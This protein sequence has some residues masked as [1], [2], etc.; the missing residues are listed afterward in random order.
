[1][2]ESNWTWLYDLKM[3]FQDEA[4]NTNNESDLIGT[5]LKNLMMESGLG[6]P[7]E[8]D[9]WYIGVHA[10]SYGPFTLCPFPTNSPW[11][12]CAMGVKR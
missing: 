7:V 1:M 10:A 8:G 9:L 6:G 4:D 5:A 2:Y 3:Y 11:F 12:S